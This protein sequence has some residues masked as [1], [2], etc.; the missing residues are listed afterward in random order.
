M[1]KKKNDKT[2]S[3]PATPP[4]STE[5]APVRIQIST[6]DGSE[7]AEALEAV[8]GR[9]PIEFQKNFYLGAF[10]KEVLQDNDK[11]IA[12]MIRAAIRG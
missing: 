5:G 11:E 4:K 7:I 8:R 2:R 12:R 6:S 10:F 1:S 9:I 3:N